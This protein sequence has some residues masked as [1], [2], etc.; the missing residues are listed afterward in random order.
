MRSIKRRCPGH[1]EVESRS[2]ALDQSGRAGVTAPVA[3]VNFWA[4]DSN[5]SSLNHRHYP[6]DDYF[7]TVF[8]KGS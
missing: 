4:T 5:L 6:G 3:V 2:E 1:I 7:K 8:Q